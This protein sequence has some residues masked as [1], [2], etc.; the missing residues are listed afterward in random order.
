MATQFAAKVRR[1][2]S[3]PRAKMLWM[4]VTPVVLLLFVL[5]A[6]TAM[7]LLKQ[8][9]PLRPLYTRYSKWRYD[10]RSPDEMGDGK[11]AREILL[12]GPMGLA[13]DSFG[14]VFVSDR[15]A[16]FVW[17]IAASGKATVIAGTGLSVSAKSS[18]PARVRAREAAF[19][20]PE[21]LA[22]DAEGNLF[23]ADS[24][25][26]VVFK[27]D[28]DG[29]RTIFAGSVQAGHSG[30][31]GPATVATLRTPYDVRLDAQGNIYIADMHNHAVRKVDR[32]GLIT[33]AAGT[34]TGTA[35]YGGDGGPATRAQL[36]KPYGLLLDA[37]GQLLITDSEN[38]RIRRVGR[39]GIITTI[40]GTG[41]AGFSGDGGPATA[42][43]FN[44]PQSLALDAHGRL[45]IGDEHNHALRAIE[46][47]GTVRTIIGNHGH[48]YAGDGGLAALAQL[49]D[50]EN[51]LVR[52]DGALLITARDNARVRIIT[53]DGKINTWAG[54]GPSAKHR[55]Q[56]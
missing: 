32:A 2:T 11:S 7:P 18:I 39:D 3:S 37:D 34:G 9:K 12:E 53:P 49:A 40:A 10:W 19:G 15:D 43:Q 24:T 55:Y 50:P 26:N 46:P 6:P 54:R 45:Y 25:L 42:A 48:G 13:E 5:S 33:T 41:T 8:L 51:L 23:V 52:R 22:L 27:I 56:P 1:A 17:Q 20:S 14:N 16:R 44:V 35:G 30:D 4:A 21:G 31:G 47:D 38:N 36:N 29:W 28:R